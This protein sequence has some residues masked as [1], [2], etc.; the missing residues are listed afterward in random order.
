MSGRP[1]DGLPWWGKALYAC[2][3]API[4]AY[5]KVVEVKDKIKAKLRRKL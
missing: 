5:D 4:I 1:T 2:V 3:L